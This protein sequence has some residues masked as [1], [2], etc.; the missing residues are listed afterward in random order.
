M[1]RLRQHIALAIDGG[2]VRGLIAA[3][4]LVALE[5][6]LK[7][8]PLIQHEQMK[9]LVGTSTGAIITAGIAI[10]MKA[11]EIV[12]LYLKTAQETVPPNHY[13]GVPDSLRGIYKAFVGLLKPSLYNSDKFREQLR[14][15]LAKRGKN[16]DMTLGE[17]QREMRPDQTLII[18]TVNIQERRTHF[19]KT[20]D[21]NDAHWKVWEAVMASCAAPTVLPLVAKSDGFYADGGTG[22]YVNPVYIAAR[23]ALEWQRLAAKQVSLLSFGTGWLDP[24]VVKKQYGTPDRWRLLAWAANA[25]DILLGDVSRGQGFDVIHDFPDLDFRRFQVTLD[26]KVD[27]DD[28]RQTTLDYLARQGEFVLNRAR[29]NE[30]APNPSAEIDPERLYE[31]L[32]RRRESRERARRVVASSN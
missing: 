29:R 21:E 18:T 26:R 11:S 17:L 28:A 2:G 16:P 5:E 30:Y 1:Q 13:Y 27:L 22:S 24:Q 3:K 4:A 7:G 9:V 15:S 14:D 25:V 19:L 8:A 23:E 31:A 20:Y 12:E 10:G 32:Q 6:G